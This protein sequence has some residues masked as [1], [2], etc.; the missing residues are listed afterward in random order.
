[1][2]IEN[3]SMSF[4]TQSIFENISFEINNYEKV[5][6][7][8]VNGA[9]KST[10][11]NLILGLLTPDSGKVIIKEENNVGYLPQVIEINPEEDQ[12]VLEYLLKGR[13]IAKLKKN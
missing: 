10:L 2:K 9:G 6:I 1:M 12:T 13:P 11:F 5:G 8:G 7:V 3:L 4:G